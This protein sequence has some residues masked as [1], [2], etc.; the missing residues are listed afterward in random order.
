[1]KVIDTEAGLSK[2]I[3][4]CCFKEW[5]DEL[6]DFKPNY[7]GDILEPEFLNTK[8]PLVLFTGSLGLGYGLFSGIPC[9]N[10]NECCDMIIALIK[11]PN[12][13]KVTLIPD[14]PNGCDIVDTDFDKI[15]NTGE[16]SFRM[17]ARI[18]I[19]EDNN[20]IIRSIP[21]RTTL[22][23]IMQEQIPNLVEKS[24]LK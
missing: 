4:D 19:D 2:F 7:S 13:K 16:G 10:L 1:M 21:Y 24:K 23:K 12:K 14:F 17:R 6:I 18:D 3:W 9:Y 5:R 22:R 8:Y 11:D 20:L 15:S